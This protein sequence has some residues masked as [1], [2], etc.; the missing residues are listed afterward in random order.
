MKR[1]HMSVSIH[2]IHIMGANVLKLFHQPLPPTFDVKLSGLPG[3]VATIDVR[4]PHS[5]RCL[6]PERFRPKPVFRQVDGSKT[7]WRPSTQG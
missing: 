6:F 3:F 1:R 2:S 7:Q 5:P 4:Y